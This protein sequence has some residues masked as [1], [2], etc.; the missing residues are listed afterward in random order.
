MMG[1]I[2]SKTFVKMNSFMMAV[3]YERVKGASNSGEL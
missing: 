1:N 3:R 2:Y